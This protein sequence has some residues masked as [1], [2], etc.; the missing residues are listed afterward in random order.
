MATMMKQALVGVYRPFV[1]IADQSL[2]S[3]TLDMT[4]PS[5]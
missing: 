5:K 3:G 1:D 2:Y 4:N